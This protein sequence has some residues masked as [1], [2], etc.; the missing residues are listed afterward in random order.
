MPGTR[1]VKCNC[2]HE[3]QDKQYGPQQRLA[4]VSESGNT[5]KCTSCGNKHGSSNKK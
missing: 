4:N 5:A 1:I 2:T 3:F